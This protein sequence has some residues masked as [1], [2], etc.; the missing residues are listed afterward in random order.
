MTSDLEVCSVREP[1]GLAACFG[2]AFSLADV[3]A[4]A[5]A[6]EQVGDT[7]SAVTR[8]A[9]LYSSTQPFRSGAGSHQLSIAHKNP[10]LQKRLTRQGVDL[11]TARIARA[12]RIRSLVRGVAVE[13][14]ARVRTLSDRLLSCQVAAAVR[15]GTDYRACAV[16]VAR[17]ATSPA[18]ERCCGPVD[19]AEAIQ[20]AQVS[21]RTAEAVGSVGA[22]TFMLV[23]CN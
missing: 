12:V 22:V 16:G 18:V 14:V 10:P 21:L 5:V 11:S 1:E 19:L 17:H 2:L 8:P 3:V 20:E 23:V 7:V 9:V 15:V 13:L 4:A 6:A